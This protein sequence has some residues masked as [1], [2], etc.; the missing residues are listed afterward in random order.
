MTDDSKP[1]RRRGRALRAAVPRLSRFALEH[2]LLLPLGAAIALIWVNSAP[3]SYYLFTYAIAF[4]VNDVA[5]VFFF[6]LM[7]KEV[8]EATAPGGVLHPWR[9]ALLPVVA[10]IGATA[11]PA[12]I[13]IWIV[14]VLDEPMLAVA[15]PVPLA[16]DLAV[17]YFVL[18]LIFRPHPAIPFLLLLAIAS[19]ALGFVALALFNPTQDLHLTVGVLMLAVAMSIARGLR[20]AGIKSFWPYLI[21]AGSLSWF[22]LYWSGIHPALAMVPILPFLPHAARDPGFFVDA[23]PGARDTL[24]RFE[25]GG[26]IPRSWRCSSWARQRRRAPGRAGARHLGRADRGPAGKAARHSFGNRRR[27]GRWPA[28]A[29]QGRLARVDRRWLCQRHRLQRGVVLLH[30][31]AASGPTAVRSEH[32]GAAHACRGAAGGRLRPAAGGW[33][34][35]GLVAVRVSCMIAAPCRSQAPD[36]VPTRSSARSAPAAWARCIERVIRG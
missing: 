24:S 36:S 31:D 5:M 30:R 4:A 18:R 32:G 17:S 16:T 23:P 2:L 9:R 35:R 28:L 29:P 7:T 1:S 8:V 21:A 12:L 19:D 34:V 14:G 11:V 6:A 20:G 25:S 33:Q 26:D 3:E 13:Y 15:W 27:P 10:S 22:A